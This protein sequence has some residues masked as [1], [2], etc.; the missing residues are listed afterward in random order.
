MK[1]GSSD[2]KESRQRGKVGVKGGKPRR[3]RRKRISEAV[4][5][6][7]EKKCQSGRKWLKGKDN[8]NRSGYSKQRRSGEVRKGRTKKRGRHVL[9]RRIAVFRDCAGGLIKI[10]LHVHRKA[11]EKEKTEGKKGVATTRRKLY[12]GYVKCSS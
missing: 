11:G 1:S 7:L 4:E 2:M 10:G 5:T 8:L 3:K 12:C 9:K 6:P